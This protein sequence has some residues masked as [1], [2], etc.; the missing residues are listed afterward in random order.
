MAESN[1]ETR[2]PRLVGLDAY[3]GFVML[4][5]ASGGFALA[6]VARHFPDSPA[7]Q[8]LAYQFEH[9]AW[10]G[11]SF[12]DMIQ[13]S[14]MFMV[15]V[16]MPFSYASRRARGQSWPQ[17]ARHA[18]LRSLVLVALGV[19]LS[20]AWSKQTNY[21]FVNVLCQMGLGY[22]AVFLLLGRSPRVQL[23]AAA[24]ILAGYWLWFAAYPLP[25]PAASTGLDRKALGLPE[26]W[27]PLTGFFAHWERNT[28]PAAAFDRWFLN[29]FPRPP[30]DPYTFN[31]G[32]YQ[33]LNFIPSIATM[34]FGLMA[35]ELIRG[36]RP[37]AAKLRTLVVAGMV[38]LALGSV[39]DATACPI[40][41]RI[42]T[43][44]WA[45]YSTG[46]TCLQLAFFHGLVDVL[47]YRRWAFPL[48]VVGVNSIAIY[49]MAQL[50]KPFVT[51]TLKIHLGRPWEALAASP[52][53]GMHLEPQLFGGTYGPIVQ[54]AAVLLGFWLI[55]LW[56]YRQ[57]IFVKI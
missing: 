17:L 1:L 41:K 53:S 9:T 39:L 56:M 33:T 55:C 44:S 54:S 45:I 3:R 27:Q 32:G 51:S 21:T 36:A 28:N 46:W 16:A 4:T 48:V 40:V 43:P 11:C 50:M 47:G 31:E 49:V 19:F 35:G 30:H 34:I 10:R 29:L 20:S 6:R 8:S 37:A 23:A 24:A 25:F 57:K 52:Y 38:C 18:L 14:F 2:P 22:M 5:M 12:W 42:W 13:P 15:G 7:W 26:G